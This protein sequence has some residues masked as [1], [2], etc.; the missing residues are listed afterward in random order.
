MTSRPCLA[1]TVAGHLPCRRRFAPA[2]SAAAWAGWRFAERCRAPF[3]TLVI[4]L[5]AAVAE[6]SVHGPLPARS[7]SASDAP[8]ALP[9]QLHAVCGSGVTRILAAD[10]LDGASQ[11]PLGRGP[12]GW[13]GSCSSCR[14]LMRRHRSTGAQE[15]R[16]VRVRCVVLTAR[17]A[18]EPIMRSYTSTW[19]PLYWGVGCRRLIGGSPFARTRGQGPRPGV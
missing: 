10:E 4:W 12:S 8:L 3:R 6:R 17:I 9:A 15:P 5:S 13:V 18:T 11:R 1:F 19:R 2:R 14:A 7:V 16:A